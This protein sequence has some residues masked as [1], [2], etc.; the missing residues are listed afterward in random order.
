MSK[1][2]TIR[3]TLVAMALA[4][5]GVGGTALAEQEV[6]PND[7]FSQPQKLEVGP[8]GAVTVFGAIQNTGSDKTFPDTDFYSFEGQKDDFIT[9]DIDGGAAGLNTVLHLFSPE[10]KMKLFSYYTD[11]ADPGSTPEPGSTTTLD[12]SLQFSLDSTGTWKVAVTAWPAFMKDNGEWL[13]SPP[14]ALSNGSYTLIV[15]GLTPTTTTEQVHIEIKPGSNGRGPINPKA[16]GEIPVALL[17]NVDTGFDPFQV[18][19]ASLR[20]GRTGTEASFVRCLKA[21]KDF[22]GDG[23]LDRVCHFDNEKSGFTWLDSIGTVTGTKGGKPFEGRGDL[24]VVPAEK[25]N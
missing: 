5:M 24:K 4:T 13:L 15:S 19:E 18:D 21:G 22:N 17:S 14:R 2:Q 23:R 6:E 25:T 9:V 1:Q 3:R 10:G 11:P 7:N 16:K 8:G 20:F 12:A